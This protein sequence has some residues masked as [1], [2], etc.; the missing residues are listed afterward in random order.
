MLNV[1]RGA[2]CWEELCTKPLR[3]YLV[4]WISDEMYR[5]RLV[6]SNTDTGCPGG[7]YGF[8]RYGFIPTKFEYWF[9]RKQ[10]STRSSEVLRKVKAALPELIG[11]TVFTCLQIPF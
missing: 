9:I 11:I 8:R 1:F 2:I 3:G 5:R 7:F 4:C 10:V 6:V